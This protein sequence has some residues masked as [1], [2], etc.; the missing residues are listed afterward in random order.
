MVIVVVV[1]VVV[2]MLAVMVVIFVVVIV[3]LVLFLDPCFLDKL[4][5]SHFATVVV[6]HQ[7]QN[8][9]SRF[10]PH[11]VSVGARNKL[12]TVITEAAYGKSTQA[13]VSTPRLASVGTARSVLAFLASGEG[14]NLEPSATACERFSSESG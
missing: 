12:R 7:E 14:V 8:A 2:M 9:R 6:E 4:A 3:A 5:A 11:G 13:A 1:V 10:P